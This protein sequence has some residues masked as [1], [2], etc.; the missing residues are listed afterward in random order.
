MGL[1]TGKVGIIMGVANQ[2]SIATSVAQYL[3]QEGA[4]LGF[5]HLPDPAGQDKM[6]RRVTN[7]IQG[8]DPVLLFPCDV[9]K[10][11]DLDRFFGEVR[12]K[13]GKIDFLVHS[14][15][16]APL[17][18]IRCRTIDASRAG[19]L[20][21][22]DVSVYSLIAIAKRAEELLN[23]QGS[24]VAMTYLGGERV[25]AGYNLMGLCKAALDQG[26]RYLAN[27]LGPKG[28]RVNAVSAGPIKTLAS[29]AVGD[30]S[31]ILKI[32]PEIAPLR[33]NISTLDVAKASAY[34]LSDLASGTTGEILHVD[35]GYNLIATPALAGQ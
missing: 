13:L 23:D 3:Q 1:F 19:F 7:A 35:A 34:L 15:A 24:I 6:L 17:E 25:V 4:S 28:I 31:R 12:R 20:Q 9:T 30:F 21:A 26:V 2:F 33:R 29:S 18:D 27:E 32:T 22:M 14:I 8:I 16:F 5:S 10:D 11:E